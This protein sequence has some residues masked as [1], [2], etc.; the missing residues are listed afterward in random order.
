MATLTGHSDVVWGVAVTPDGRLAVSASDDHTSR[1]WRLRDGTLL[2]T[3]TGEGVGRSCAVAS[4]RSA[5]VAGDA[6]GRVH[7]LRLEGI[8]TFPIELPILTPHRIWLYGEH[9]NRGRWANHLTAECHWCGQHF[10]VPDETLGAITAI[11]RD[12]DLSPDRSPCLELPAEAW[13]EPRLLSECPLCHNP[14]RVNPFVLDGSEDERLWPEWV[15]KQELAR[16]LSSQAKTLKD[17]GDLEQ[18]ARALYRQ[19]EQLRR[20]LGDKPWSALWLRI[21]ALAFRERGDLVGAL[22]LYK[23]QED[24]CR[25]LGDKECLA[26]SLSNQAVL[27]AKM[28][29]ADEALPL[30]EEAHSLATNHGLAALA[31]HIKGVLDS[32]RRKSAD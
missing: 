20:K 2:A 22:A 30:A 8:Q 25:E 31:E 1:V 7:V 19:E 32:V 10:P 18:S 23:E 24:I 16:S 6:L 27:L 12:A 3:F 21:R 26:R 4:D 15:N 29:R 14:L 13:D 5:I 9:G 11:I 28:E 17:H